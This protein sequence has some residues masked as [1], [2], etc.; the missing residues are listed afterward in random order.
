M[1]KFLPEEK[2]YHEPKVDGQGR[3]P[4]QDS[5]FVDTQKVGDIPTLKDLRW[6]E[7]S[8]CNL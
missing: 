7:S 1:Q 4:L 5:A 6:E 3:F 8:M 2:L